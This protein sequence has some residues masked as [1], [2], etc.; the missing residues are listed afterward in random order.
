MM[1]RIEFPQIPK[2]ADPPAIQRDSPQVSF[3][4]EVDEF[5][6]ASQA[7]YSFQVSGKGLCAAVLDTGLNTQHVDFAGRIAAVRNFT[8]DYSGDP[9]NVTDGNGH[10]TNVAGIILSK[11]DHTG[12]APEAHVAVLKVLAD[13]GGGSFGWVEQALDWVLNNYTKNKISAVCMSLG[14]GGNYVQDRPFFNDPIKRQIAALRRARVPVVVAAGN[15]YYPH[16][17]QQGMGYPAIIRQTV[18]VGAVYDAEEGGFQYRS[19]A[20]AFSSRAGQITP[21]SQ[22]L[23]PTANPVTRTE[24]FA[25]GAPVTS[26]GINGPHGESVQHGTSQATPVTVGVILLLQEYY[27]RYAGELPTVTQ[28]TNWLRRGGVR[29]FDGDDEDDNVKHTNLSFLRLDAVRALDAARREL[30]RR[31]LIAPA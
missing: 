21:F 16:N 15:D 13:S 2:P 17:S 30:G 20:E 9:H 25:P 27:E 22:R 7:R 4:P 5:V 18:S 1:K 12:I 3:L 8:T 14:D 23:H 24:I 29:I 6:R 28:L 26:S 11:G 10:G 19:G 31:G